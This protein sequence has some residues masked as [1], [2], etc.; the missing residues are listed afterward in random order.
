MR[1]DHFI[2][3]KVFCFVLSVSCRNIRFG[4]ISNFRPTNCKHYVIIVFKL[5]HFASSWENLSQQP[6]SLILLTLNLRGNFLSFFSVN[7]VDFGK[8][9]IWFPLSSVTKLIKYSKPN[10]VRA[11]RNADGFC[12]HEGLSLFVTDACTMYIAFLIFFEKPCSLISPTLNIRD[13]FLFFSVDFVDFGKA[14]L[15]FPFSDEAN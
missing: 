14:V 5:V 7:F 6:C 9:F 13:N 8:E 15:W 11:R 1:V 10:A 3:Y 4:T 2:K 12:V